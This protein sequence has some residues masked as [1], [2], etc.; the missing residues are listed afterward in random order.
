MEKL[1]SLESKIKHIASLNLYD[2]DREEKKIV[3]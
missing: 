2:R 1:D 3:N